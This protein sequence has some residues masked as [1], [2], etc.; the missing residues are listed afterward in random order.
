MEDLLKKW[1]KDQFDKIDLSPSSK[2]WDNISMKLDEWPKYWYNSNIYKMNAE[3]RESTWEG[4]KVQLATENYGT[5]VNRLSYVAILVVIFVISSIPFQISDQSEVYSFKNGFLAEHRSEPSNTEYSENQNE[6][7]VNKT[8]STNIKKNLDQKIE[9]DKLKPS[10]ISIVKNQLFARN[11]DLP[12]ADFEDEISFS[13]ENQLFLAIKDVEMPTRK[14]VSQ[15]DLD[16]PQNEINLKGDTYIGLSVTPQLSSL[17]N[18]M[19]DKARN[20]ENVEMNNPVSIGFDLSYEKYISKQNSIRLNL[21][22]NN[23]KRLNFDEHNSFNNESIRKEINL[24]YISMDMNYSRNWSLN[25]SDNLQ[26][27]AFA[28]IY[29]GYLVNKSVSYNDERVG[30][31]EDGFRNIDFGTSAGILL[32]NKISPKMRIEYGFVTQIGV[33]N[34]FKGTDVLPSRY[35]K[36]TS[37]SYGMSI[38]VVRSF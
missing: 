35:F 22:A 6:I 11:I 9:S 30:Y 5:R 19:S 36:N 14:V 21:R 38:G 3:P 16:T 18:P 31:I 23:V 25:K 8:R 32:S 7:V 26:L 12:I 17:L 13:Q 20:S 37:H 28:G 2:V 33:I 1:Y 15:V 4:L 29:T 24:N 27:K 10:S 34:S